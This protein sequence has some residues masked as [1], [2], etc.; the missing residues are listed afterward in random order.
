MRCSLHFFGFVLFA[1]SLLVFCPLGRLNA[2]NVPPKNSSAFKSSNSST[3]IRSGLSVGA[4]WPYFGLKYFFNEDFGSEF[5]FAFGDGI[6][7]CAVRGYWSFKKFGNFSLFTGLEG[8]YITFDTMNVYNTM[9]VS[10]TGYEVSPFLGIEYFFVK[11][12]SFMF[13]FSM[14]IIG[15]TSR[16]VTLGGI[17]WVTNGALYI[18]PF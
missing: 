3:N 5:R 9:K 18:Y 13:D 7:D 10:G 11:R 8:G 2:A 15:L 1:L 17:Q 4:G 16:D 12:I 14:P 6:N